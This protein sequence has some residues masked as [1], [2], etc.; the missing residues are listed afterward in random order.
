[1]QKRAHGI[2]F[3]NLPLVVAWQDGLPRP[4]STEASRSTDR[5]GTCR[6]SGSLTTE[7]QPID[8]GIHAFC[9]NLWLRDTLL[10]CLTVS[11]PT[12]LTNVTQSSGK[13]NLAQSS[14]LVAQP[15]KTAFNMLTS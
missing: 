11:P 12:F 5:A 9:S 4:V 14:Q 3:L 15:H 7:T 6:M 8:L 2:S 1:M 13:S 10:T